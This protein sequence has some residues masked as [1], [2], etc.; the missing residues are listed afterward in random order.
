MKKLYPLIAKATH[1]QGK[2]GRAEPDAE[3]E[4]KKKKVKASEVTIIFQRLCE[5]L[6]F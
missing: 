1:K 5:A 3:Q 2:E 6:K 4:K